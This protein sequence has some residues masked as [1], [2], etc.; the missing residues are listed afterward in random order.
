MVMNSLLNS[1]PAGDRDSVLSAPYSQFRRTNGQRWSRL[2][3]KW[4]G[5]SRQRHTLA[6]L[7]DRLLDDVGITRRQAAHEIAKPFWR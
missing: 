7:D 1:E 4:I 3:R 2:I 5:R 6:G